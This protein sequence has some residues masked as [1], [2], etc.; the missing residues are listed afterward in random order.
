MQL[1]I[2]T[3]ENKLFNLICERVGENEK[4]KSVATQNDMK[5][6]IFWADASCRRR[7]KC[8]KPV[9][10]KQDCFKLWS[11]LSKLIHFSLALQTHLTTWKMFFFILSLS[12]LS[13]SS[14]WFQIK[15]WDIWTYHWFLSHLPSTNSSKQS[16]NSETVVSPLMMNEYLIAFQGNICLTGR[17]NYS[18]SRIKRET[19]TTSICFHYGTKKVCENKETQ[20]CGKLKEGLSALIIHRY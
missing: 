10:V 1:H 16:I 13:L 8:T 5:N 4:W 12:S 11:K 19:Q 2:L 14:Y 3:C 18:H 7:T 20:L 17:R 15:R 6:D 9:I